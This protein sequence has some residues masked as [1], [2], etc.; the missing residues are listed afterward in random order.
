MHRNYSLVLRIQFNNQLL[1]NVFWNVFTF[2]N[3][4]ES[5]SHDSGIPFNP[6]IFA[7]VKT[8]QRIGNNFHRFVLFTNSNHMPRLHLERRYVHHLAIHRDVPVRHQL[9]GGSASRCKSQPI[10]HIIQTAFQQLQQ[11][12]PRH[13]RSTLSFFIGNAELS[14]QHPICIFCFLL[15]AQL[16]TV[17]R[18]FTTTRIAMLSR[19]I[20]FLRQNLV[21]TENRFTK[22]ARNL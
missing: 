18:S 22:L 9:T 10:N 1:F 21:W 20:V 8:I 13:T 17:F 14:F 19:R 12:N 6:R 7:V 2:R 15:F 5:S 16:N 11:Y 3:M 4:Q